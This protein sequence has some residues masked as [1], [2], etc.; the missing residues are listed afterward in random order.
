MDF[1]VLAAEAGPSSHPALD[2]FPHEPPIIVQLEALDRREADTD[3]YSK[4]LA[5][6]L[7]LIP[8]VLPEHASQLIEEL[9]PT[10]GDEVG[11]WVI[12]N[13]LSNPSYPRTEKFGVGKGKKKFWNV[14]NHGTIALVSS[15]ANHNPSNDADSQPCNSAPG[16]FTLPAYPRDS[17]PTR[18]RL[19]RWIVA[20]DSY[21]VRF[22]N[23]I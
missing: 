15:T 23:E 19:K 7:E 12:Q 1:D 5:H 10:Y 9:Y 21:L 14:K 20:P 3:P 13:L 6:V 11:G 22:K 17:T 8:E 4:H 16:Q 2:P 18:P